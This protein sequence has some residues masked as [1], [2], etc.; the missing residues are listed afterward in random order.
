MNK[1]GCGRNKNC[2]VLEE[3]QVSCSKCT[4]VTENIAS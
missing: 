2:L 4:I 3:V 1:T